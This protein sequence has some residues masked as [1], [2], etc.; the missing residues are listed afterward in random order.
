MTFVPLCEKRFFWMKTDFLIIGSG[1]AGLRGAIELS[2]YGKVLIVTKDRSFESSSSYAQGGIAVV[3]GEDDT[4]ESHI[5]DTLKAGSGLCKKQTVKVLVEEGPALVKQIIEWGVKFDKSNGKYLVGLEGAHSRRRILHFRD[6]TGEEIVRVLREKA[7]ENPNISKL[8]KHFI[9]D[10]IITDGVCTGAVLLNEN[11]G[12]IFPV[13][14]KATILATGGAGH[15]YSRTSNPAG[16]TGDGFAIA[17]RGGA[18]LS[19][20]EFVQ[21]HPTSFSLNNAP[22][23]LITEALRGEGAVLRNL[24]KRR[25]MSNYHSLGELAPRDELS[26]AIIHEMGKTHADYVFLD[27]TRIKQTVLKERFPT[28]YKACM[29]YGIDITKDMIPVSPA[30][31]FMIGGVQTDGWGR[32]TVTGLFAAGEVASTGVHGANR[33]ASNSLLEG[34]V[35]GR[36]TGL[37]AAEYANTVRILRERRIKDSDIKIK[38]VKPDSA[39]DNSTHKN[40]KTGSIREEIKNTMWKNAGI[41]RSKN[42]LEQGIK[43]I[44]SLISSY[45]IQGI[46]RKELETLNMLQTARFIILSALKRKESVGANYREDFPEWS[47]KVRHTKLKIKK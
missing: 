37:A 14:A 21:F 39:D 32:T 19:D 45:E 3:T 8:P 16:A 7:I 26:R 34:L 11:S 24:K 35:F 2:Q 46:T 36:R 18:V 28:A 47:G 6:S 4:F 33:L 38:T 10:L 1:I 31:H 12:E 42:S 29:Q 9:V 5:E 20:M 30:A 41:I 43:E 13:F 15:V 22:S 23:F 25:F 44:D 27:A 40:S 17:Y